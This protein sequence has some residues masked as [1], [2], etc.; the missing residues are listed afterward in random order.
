MTLLQT[1]KH[2]AKIANK[3]NRQLR[4]LFDNTNEHGICMLDSV[5]RIVNWNISAEKLIGYTSKE[6]IGKNYSFFFSDEEIR[7]RVFKKALA[8]ATRKG[9]FI[10]EGIRVRKDGSHFWA[11]SFITFVKNIKKSGTFFVL[12]TQDITRAREIEQKREEYIGI[13]SHELKTPITTLSLY[14]ELLA[15][16]LHLE[17][18]QKNLKMLRDIQS[19]T[20]RL[21]HL[22]DDLLIV[23]KIEGGKLE[24]HKEVFN[25]A[26]LVERTVRDFQIA[27]SKHKII[28]TGL[29]RSQVRADKDRVAQVLIN[30]LGN[31]VK[32]SPQADKVFVR[33]MQRKN[34][35][36]ISVQDLGSGIGKSDQREIFTRFF[37][38]KDAEVG[39]VTGVGLGLYISKE[40]I[41]KHRERIW[42][43]SAKKRG[44]TFFFTLPSA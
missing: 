20:A 39:D 28:Y 23:T 12:I 4:V 25:P 19:Q 1:K 36:I 16:R 29:F 17:S 9:S 37:R 42:V 34:K 10:A 7:Q 18:D 3:N 32:Y 11:R 35:C 22:I 5:G 40:I 44:S 21:V 13:A 27:A 15:E 43:E 41:K 24:L 14:S 2:A 8:I 30:L 33:I 31:A 38:T 6:V 26:T